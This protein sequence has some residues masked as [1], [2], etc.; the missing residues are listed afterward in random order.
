[1]KV[2]AVLPA[3]NA[4]NTLESTFRAIPKEAVHEVVLVDDGSLDA[5]SARA[6][7]IPG[8]VCLRHAQNR[9]Y[10]GSQKTG[11]DWALE[12]NAD[13]VVMVHA[14]FQYDPTLVPQ[15]VAP[16]RCGEADMVMGS[17]FINGDPRQDGMPWW[18]FY[19]NRFLTCFQNW[20]WGTTLSECHSGYRAYSRSFLL[21]V[22]YREFSDQ[23]VFDS[24]MIAAAAKRKARIIEIAIPCRYEPSCSSI[25]F[26]R[27]VRYGLS[28]LYTFLS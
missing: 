28:T 25:S 7:A 2:V 10:G 4:A 23:F 22:P 16:I 6:S 14:D 17:R 27:S 21:S 5:T 8:L 1:M 19:G 12:S 9:G 26:G 15:M 3:Y 18:R 13:I 11:Y 24:E 20:R